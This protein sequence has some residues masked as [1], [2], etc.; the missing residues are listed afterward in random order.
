MLIGGGTKQNY[1][2][3]LLFVAGLVASAVAVYYTQIGGRWLLPT[4]LALIFMLAGS[5]LVAARK[6]EG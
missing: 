1:A 2:A 4:A 6:E 5:A 3:L